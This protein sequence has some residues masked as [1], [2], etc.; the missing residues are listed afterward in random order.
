MFCS[1]QPQT[2]SLWYILFS[3]LHFQRLNFAEPSDVAFFM[4]EIRREIGAHQFLCGFEADYSGS[5]HQHIHRI[6]FDSLVRRV[7]VVTQSGAN[8]GQLVRG[9]RCADAAAADQYT[10]FSLPG[11]NRLTDGFSDVRIINRRGV[12]RTDINDFVL[13][14]AQQCDVLINPRPLWPGHDNNFS[15]KVFEYALAGRAILTSRVSGVDLVL[16]EEAFYFDETDFDRSLGGALVRVAETPRAELRRR[17]AAIQNRL[18]TE[19]SWQR[20]GERLAQFIH[21]VLGG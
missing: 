18:L 13:Q 21:A 1:R 4:G 2:D 20:Q 5:Q 3:K 12:V 8:A 17:G 19:F 15:S 9:D 14:F 16:G 11:K 7:S 6:V 10:T